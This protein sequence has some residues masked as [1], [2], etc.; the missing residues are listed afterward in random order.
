MRGQVAV[1]ERHVEPLHACRILKG[2]GADAGSHG[3]RDP[4]VERGEVAEATL[5]L[6]RVGNH[7][8]ERDDDLVDRVWQSGWQRYGHLWR[9]AI[10]RW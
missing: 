8:V 4:V 1:C 5:R 7:G 3:H 2:P 10:M 6:D 9:K